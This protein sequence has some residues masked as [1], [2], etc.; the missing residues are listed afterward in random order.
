[1]TKVKL[2]AFR[3][4]LPG[5]LIT[6]LTLFFLAGCGRKDHAVSDAPAY[7]GTSAS[8]L[9]SAA[10]PCT[11]AMTPHTGTDRIDQQIIQ[12]QQEAR[13]AKEP[14]RTAYLERLG[15]PGRN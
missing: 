13:C 9:V 8:S 2:R 7:T 4:F 10:D 12:L 11:I 14:W 6:L 15:Y 1:M 3:F 5:G